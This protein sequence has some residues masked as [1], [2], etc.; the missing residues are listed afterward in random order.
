MIHVFLDT[1]LFREDATRC[2]VP[3]QVLKRLAVGRQVK[4][5]VSDVTRSEFASQ[6]T[7]LSS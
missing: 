7:P 1:V 4:I 3:F 6:Q 5:F 2:K